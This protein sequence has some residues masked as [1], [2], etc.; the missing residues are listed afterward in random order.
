MA[1]LTPDQPP[2]MPALPSGLDASAPA[3]TNQIASATTATVGDVRTSPTGAIPFQTLVFAALLLLFLFSLVLTFSAHQS[4]QKKLGIQLAVFFGLLGIVLFFAKASLFGGADIITAPGSGLR[5][6]VSIENLEKSVKPGEKAHFDITVKNTANVAATNGTLNLAFTDGREDGRDYQAQTVTLSN[7]EPGASQVIEAEVAI[8]ARAVGAVRAGAVVEWQVTGKPTKG[9]TVAEVAAPISNPKFSVSKYVGMYSLP[10]TLSGTTPAADVVGKLSFNQKLKYAF[11]YDPSLPGD[12][13]AKWVD[14]FAQKITLDKDPA[15]NRSILLYSP[16]ETESVDVPNFASYPDLKTAQNITLYPGW[17]MVGN[18]YPRPV[19]LDSAKAGADTYAKAVSAGTIS[20]PWF[21]TKEIKEGRQVYEKKDVS[22]TCATGET[23]ADVATSPVV[24]AVSEAVWIQNKTDQNVTLTFAAPG[25]PKNNTTAEGISKGVQSYKAGVLYGDV[26]D[27][28]AITQAD[29]NALYTITQG[30]TKP[31]ADELKRIK[32]VADLSPVFADKSFGDGQLTQDDVDVILDALAGGEIAPG[33]TIADLLKQTPIPTTKYLYPK[34]TTGHGDLNKDGKIT[35]ADAEIVMSAVDKLRVLTAEEAI[36]ADVAPVSDVDGSFGDGK[37]TMG[38]VTKILQLAGIDTTPPKT[39][40]PKEEAKGKYQRGDTSIKHGDT[41]GNNAIEQADADLALSGVLKLKTLTAEQIARA[42]LAP[43]FPDGS[44][45][46]GKLEM[47][48]VT[49]ILKIVPADTTKPSAC[50]YSKDDDKILHGDTDGNGV[51]EMADATLALRGALGVERLNADQTARAD[52]APVCEDGKFG[53]GKV[54]AKDVTLIE[55]LVNEKNPPKEEPVKDPDPEPVS[56][57]AKPPYKYP[58]LITLGGK[59][60]VYGDINQD[61]VTNDADG[62][63]TLEV[64]TGKVKMANLPVVPGLAA[65][66]IADLY[67]FDAASKTHG[68]GKITNQDVTIINRIAAGIKYDVYPQPEP[69]KSGAG[70][71]YD[72]RQTVNSDVYG[73]V[74]GDGKTT[75]GDA[76]LGNRMLS[77]YASGVIPAEKLDLYPYDKTLKKHGDKKFTVDDVTVIGQIAIGMLRDVFPQ[78]A[79]ATP[80]VDTKPTACT[81][82]VKQ[83]QVCPNAAYTVLRGDVNTDGKIT[84]EDANL[85]LKHALGLIKLDAHQI[86]QADVEPAY[87]DGSYGDGAV[88]MK[89]TTAIAHAAGVNLADLGQ[90]PAK[91][92]KLHVKADYDAKKLVPGDLNGD[93][94][95]TVADSTFGQRILLGL[96]KWTRTD[97]ALEFIGDVSPKAADGSFGDGEYTAEDLGEIL[98]QATGSATAIAID[99]K[100]GGVTGSEPSVTPSPKSSTKPFVTPTPT[101]S[102]AAT[103]DKPDEPI[104]TPSPKTTPKSSS[105]PSPT[106]TAAAPVTIPD[107]YHTILSQ[108]PWS[109]KPVVYGDLNGDGKVTM[110]DGTLAAQYANGSKTFPLIG[111]TPTSLSPFDIADVSP[112][113]PTNKTHGDY[114]IDNNDVTMINRIAIGLSSEAYMPAAKVTPLV[115]DPKIDYGDM[116]QDGKMTTEDAS[117]LLSIVIGSIKA[118]DYQ[119]KAGDMN[120]DGKIT[121]ADVT[122]I[123]RAVKALPIT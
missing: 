98:R 79:T 97:A 101:L 113:N 90:E 39:D 9:R 114:V 59:P 106:T 35:Q 117:T 78:P 107:Y 41:D 26:D 5:P 88:T 6:Q 45:G 8:P 55:R 94:K 96:A 121:A 52:L 60:V 80:P 62:N 54:T 111:G 67:P 76:I 21:M 29:A 56:D 47:P 32:E 20:S 120:H 102:A 36:L 100:S 15:K 65:G 85:A 50:V 92:I 25:E 91:P 48:D 12:K 86:K 115:P 30:Q 28:K 11:T 1:T 19:T 10:F 66:E 16:A 104:T 87:P 43:T 22:G 14:V 122:V 42:D 82:K 75:N 84:G 109:G 63:K 33:L 119:K 74:D 53:D 13:D 58:I 68:D 34:G 108:D 57:P 7:L 71:A 24:L 103:S 49:F 95:I 3:S 70:Y 64:S 99:L 18:P 23:C 17:N 4:Q 46:D 40:P 93:G 72:I 89:D 31:G 38:D 112:W 105:K 44:F 83:G 61:G 118:T 51:Y 69:I 73:D 123:N 37:V 2:A 27:D 110:A 116:N 77:Q 81:P